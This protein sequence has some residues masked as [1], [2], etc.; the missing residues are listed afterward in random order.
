M[1]NH[2]AGKACLNPDWGGGRP[3]ML[4]NKA[5]AEL[6]DELL[7]DNCKSY[8]CDEIQEMVIEK[9]NEMIEEAGYVSVNYS[10]EI[11]ALTINNYTAELAMD[12]RYAAENS[13]IASACLLSLI[14]ATHFIPIPEDIRRELKDQSAEVRELYDM[15]TDSLGVPV[16][17]V[18]PELIT[19]T[20]DTTE[21]LYIFEGCFKKGTGQFRLVSRES[22]TERGSPAVFNMDESNDMNG[23]RIK[24]TAVAL[25]KET[26]TMKRMQRKQTTTAATSTITIRQRKY[27]IRSI[28][29]ADLVF[30][31]T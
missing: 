30:L 10:E 9:R 6:K 4:S 18:W 22:C 13:V 27:W 1:D 12:N 23:I 2:H 8:D 24:Q 16:Y 29:E 5:K 7:K 26:K 15:V 31:I 14:A 19:S 17:P 25:Q 28:S 20:D 3:S 21:Y 11:T